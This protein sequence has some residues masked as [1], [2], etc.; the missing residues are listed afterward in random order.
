MRVMVFIDF[1]NFKAS[2]RCLNSERGQNRIIDFHHINQFTLDY[3]SHNPQYE[4]QNLVHMRTYFYTG[5]FSDAILTR[6]KKYAESLSGNQLA[7]C[8]EFIEN[9]KEK[10]HRQKELF[11]KLNNSY[12]FEVRKKPLQYSPRKGIFQKGVDVQLAVDLVSN[13]YMDN[14]D[15]AMIFSGDIDLLESL[16]TIKTLGKHVV[17]MSHNN[18]VAREMKKEA[19]LYIE[20]CTLHDKQLDLFSHEFR[21]SKNRTNHA[22]L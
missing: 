22:N 5:E 9:T 14:Y 2:M 17:L 18:T 12:F 4:K 13:A 20:L 8:E 7:Q 19:D 21:K 10:K 16:R 6:M 11:E 15:I 1:D 3:L